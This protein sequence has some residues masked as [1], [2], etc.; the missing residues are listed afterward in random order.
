MSTEPIFE[1]LEANA[2]ASPYMLFGQWFR[3]A[4]TAGLPE[5]CAMTLATATADGVPDARMVLLR[6]VDERGFVFYT[7][8]R[9]RKA[10]ELA[11]N[12]RA[13]L[14]MYWAPPMRQIRVEGQVEKITAE[15]SDAY[16]R[17]RP[18]GHQLGALVSPQSQVIPDRQFLETRLQAL[19]GE[20]KE[21]DEVARPPHWG[22]YRVLAH[23]IE[24]WQGRANRLHDRLRYRRD[25]TTWSIERLAP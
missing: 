9:S 23:T 7:N 11:Q 22:G 6:G 17:S 16:F 25:G 19:L 13:A 5:P 8:Y 24:F 18:F 2:P 20:F 3:D 14:V 4:E 12:P 1:L 21:T 15:E 10:G